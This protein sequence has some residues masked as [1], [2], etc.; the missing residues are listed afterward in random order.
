MMVQTRSNKFAFFL[1]FNLPDFNLQNR[2]ACS[3]LQD[4]L[5]LSATAVTAAAIPT[6]KSK[7][8]CVNLQTFGKNSCGLLHIS[9][10]RDT[11]PNVPSFMILST[12]LHHRCDKWRHSTK[13]SCIIQQLLFDTIFLPTLSILHTLL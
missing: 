10:E 5:A 1:R 13:K 12:K 9:H 8:N 4:I 2:F 3:C 11:H 7:K 6:R